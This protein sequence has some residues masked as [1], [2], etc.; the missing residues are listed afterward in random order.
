MK[1]SKN[2][3]WFFFL[4]VLATYLV[5]SIFNWSLT[6]KALEKSIAIII[7]IL[8]IILVVLIINFLI[9]YYLKP[10]KVLKYLGKESGIKGWTIS[11]IAGILSMGPI[12]V[13]YT[14]LAQLKKQGMKTGYVASFLYSRAI[15]IPL[16]PVMIYYFDSTFVVV[17][18][19]YLIIFSILNGIAMELITKR[20]S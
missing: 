7:E 19:I 4:A 6:K 3:N 1:N 20:T 18:N 8:P 12:Y 13:W 17:L 10:K 14:T 15:K 2:N 16:L 9:F 11:I 5:I